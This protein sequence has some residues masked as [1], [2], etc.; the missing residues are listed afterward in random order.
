MH[1]NGQCVMCVSQEEA[2]HQASGGRGGCGSHPSKMLLT[3]ENQTEA[4]GR[5]G[6]AL[7]GPGEGSSGDAPY[8]CCSAMK[9]LVVVVYELM[10]PCPRPA[11]A[12]RLWTRSRGSWRSSSATG[13]RSA[14]SWWPRWRAA[15]RKAGYMPAS[16]SKS[17]QPMKNLWS[18]WRLCEG[19]TR[20]T[21]V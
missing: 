3:G 12:V 4:A 8:E 13:S 14:K 15:R 6:G 16:S 2:G 5:G 17:R 1:L 18:S 20:P 9:L 19:K 21:R 11:A 7:H 10:V